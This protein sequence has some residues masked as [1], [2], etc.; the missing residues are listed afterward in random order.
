MIRARI[1]TTIAAISLL[2]V[3]S[4][5]AMAQNQAPEAAFGPRAGKPQP[6]EIVGTFEKWSLTCD[7]L[8]APNPKDPKAEPIMVRSCGLV[9]S[10]R[11]EKNPNLG[12]S[13]VIVK[14]KENGEDVYMVRIMAPIG[15]FLPLGV[16]LE[17]DGEAVSRVP[18]SRCAPQTCVA[19]GPASAETLGKFKKGKQ[20]TFIIY[21]NPGQGFPLVID[22]AGITAAL[23]ALDK[24]A[25]KK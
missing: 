11:D 13:M 6:P 12:L 3:S 9:Q 2:C 21:D 18:F 4:L 22:L 16:A 10:V 14:T 19:M 24:E 23:E 20:A 1:I 5:A 15:V 17:I 8:P 7:N 25:A